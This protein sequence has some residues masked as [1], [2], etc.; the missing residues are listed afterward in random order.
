[1]SGK[2]S[3]FAELKR[4]RKVNYGILN[5]SKPGVVTTLAIGAFS[6]Q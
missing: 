3:F 2:L 6:C 5:E 4:W 1:M